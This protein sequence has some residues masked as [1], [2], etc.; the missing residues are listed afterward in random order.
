MMLFK[1]FQIYLRLPNCVK[2]LEVLGTMVQWARIADRE[3]QRDEGK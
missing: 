1:I 3:V 2:E